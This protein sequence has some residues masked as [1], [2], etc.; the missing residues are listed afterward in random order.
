MVS[1]S[2]KSRVPNAAGQAVSFKSWGIISPV[3]VTVS[4]IP[5]QRSNAG[6]WHFHR[7]ANHEPR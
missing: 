2:S 6:D 5:G 4:V 1:L 3:T 7:A